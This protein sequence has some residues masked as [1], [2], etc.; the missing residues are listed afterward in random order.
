MSVGRAGQGE[1]H[2][3]LGPIPAG[4]LVSGLDRNV[5]HRQGGRGTTLFATTRPDRIARAL[6]NRADIQDFAPLPTY[7]RWQDEAKMANGK[8]LGDRVN[9]LTNHVILALLPAALEVERLAK[10]KAKEEEE[11]EHRKAEAEEAAKATQKDVEATESQQGQNEDSVSA[12]GS[13]LSVAPAPVVIDEDTVM[14]DVNSAAVP[15]RDVEEAVAGMEGVTVNDPEAPSEG[16][17]MPISE[18]LPEASTEPLAAGTE[19]ASPQNAEAGP[20][21]VEAGPSGGDVAPRVTVLVHGNPVDITDTGIDPTFLEALPDEMREEVLNQHFRERRMARQEQVTD[22]QI[23][24]EFLDALPPELRAEI[25]QQERAE[26]ARN[27]APPPPAP[28]NAPA[29][30]GA[31]DIDPASFLASLDNDLRHIVLMEQEEGFL[32]TLPSHLLAEATG[33]REGGHRPPRVALDTARGA[34]PGSPSRKVAVQRDAIQLLDKNGLAT[35]VR[36]LFFPQLSRKSLLLKIYTNLCENSKTRAELLH[37]LLNILQDGTGDVTA[38][39]RSFAQLSSRN[40]ASLAAQATPKSASKA[41]AP[42]DTVSSVASSWQMAA[43]NVPN[44]VVQRSLEALTFIVSS[45]ENASRFFLTEHELPSGLKRSVSRKGKGKEKQMSHLQYPIVPLLGLLDRQTLLKT[46]TMVESLAALLASITKPLTSLKDKKDELPKEAS[47]TADGGVSA[48]DTITGATAGSTNQETPN[49]G[50]PPSMVAGTPVEPRA[51]T[52]AGMYPC[53]PSVA[54]VNVV[55]LGTQEPPVPSEQN[56]NKPAAEEPV[57]QKIPP[58]QP[59]VIPAASLRL[60]VNILTAGECSGRTFQSTLAFIQNLSSLPEARDTIAMELRSRAQDLGHSIYKDLD[61]LVDVLERDGQG[62]NVPATVAAKFS[63]A[64]S[65]QAKFL[66][67][68]KTIDYMYS[69][70]NSQASSSDNQEKASDAEKVTGIYESFRFAPLWSRLGDCLAIVEQKPDVEHMATVLLPLI[71]SL[72]VV[73][74]HVGIQP[75][76]GRPPRGSVSPRSPTTPKE[77]MEDLF[78]SFTDAH[79]KVLNLMVRNNPSLMSGSFALLVQNPRVLDFDNKRNYFYQQLRRR[80]HSREHHGTLQLNV[81]RQ[82]VFEDSYQYLQRKTGEQIKYGKLSV[83][84]YEEEGVDAGGVTREWFQILA[85]QM[86]NP[87]YALFQ[88]CAADKLTY[89][90]NRASWVNPEHLSFFKFVGRIIGKAIFDNRL[91]E[92][93]FARS[94]YRQLLGKPV[95]YRDVEWVDPEYYNSLVWILENDPT[96]LDLNFSTEA[97]EVFCRLLSF[98]YCI[99]DIF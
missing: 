97:E 46:S 19:S 99:N 6:E 14:E 86:F 71:E 62:E 32:R 26:R 22:S 81:R 68:L 61:E 13:T 16:T 11:E 3:D 82:R 40:R 30:A 80:P 12:Q 58:L 88:P 57:Q 10:Q 63:P 2:I 21:N 75:S 79:R 43:E 24:P 9:K 49:E 47:T 77:S 7:Q 51:E 35:L 36:L 25:L 91:L 55:G 28:E 72:M 42:V 73:C 60:I 23:S 54:F 83:R 29:Q 98:V 48:A 89:Q 90:P 74:K 59:P 1:L 85:R 44:L 65:D 20:S 8:F 5:L 31:V 92:A 17:D 87:N 56:A 37:L 27:Q 50:Q 94:V 95:D 78:T 53:L 34:A 96:P 18:L 76:G 66:R 69:S 67:V 41:K 84:F 64:S 70:K 52:S 33:Y 4:Q 45:N 38:V 15:A 93:Y 39:D